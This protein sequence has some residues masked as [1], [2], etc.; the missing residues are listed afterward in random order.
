MADP[1]SM[2]RLESALPAP[3]GQW[4][5]YDES[6][7]VQYRLPGDDGPCVAAKLT[8][9]P[10]RLG[11]AA[12]RVDRIAGC[13]RTGTTR[14]PDVDV[15]ADAVDAELDAVLAATTEHRPGNGPP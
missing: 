6:S 2:P 7:A 14:H 12:V 4:E 8:V 5:R 3:P 13:R 11:A 1:S 15:A 10:D 9:R